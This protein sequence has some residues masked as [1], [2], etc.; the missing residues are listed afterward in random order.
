M[1]V[2]GKWRM[3]L[4]GARDALAS[5]LLDAMAPAA[6][7]MAKTAAVGAL[8]Q[9][10]LARPGVIPIISPIFIVLLSAGVS[11]SDLED[12]ERMARNPRS[13]FPNVVL[14]V[15]DDQ[16]AQMSA[17]GTK[18]VST[19]FMDQLAREGTLFTN[20]FS[21]S[22]SCSPSRASILTGMYP[23]AH[24][25]WRNVYSPSLEDDDIQ[26]TRSATPVDHVG[27]HEYLSTLP[28][29]LRANGYFTAI[30]QKLGAGPPW[31][32]PYDARRHTWR[33]PRLFKESIGQFIEEAGGRP[34]FIQANISPP[35]R[36]FDYFRFHEKMSPQFLPHPGRIEV[37]GYLAD[38]PVMREDLREY[39][40]SI[41]VADAAVGAVLEALKGKDVY[42]DALIIFTSDNGEP[43]H[44]AKASPYYAGLHVPFIAKGPG[45]P[46]N[47]TSDA[48][49]SHID[50]MPTILDYLGIGIPES[51][52]GT[53]LNFSPSGSGRKAAVVHSRKY[54]FGEH[55]SHGPNRNQ[56]YPSRA[57]FDGRFY[58]IE[59]LLPDRSY[60]LPAD[61]REEEVWGNRSY[62]ATLQARE[63]HPVQYRL[64]KQLESGRSREELYDMQN[65]PW[66]LS[67]LAGSDQHEAK[68]VELRS[69]LAQWRI[70]TGD[71]ANDP[72]AIK[73]R[74]PMAIEEIGA[75]IEA[76]RPIVRGDFDVYLG[77]DKLALVY[78]RERCRREDF[79]IPFFLHVVPVD[80]DVLSDGH[81][82]HGFDNIGIAARGHEIEGTCIAIGHLP[83]YPIAA[84][85]TGQYMREGRVR[86]GSFLPRGHR[87]WEGEMRLDI[88]AQWISGVIEHMQ[89]VIRSDFDVYHAGNLL[90]YT[91]ERCSDEDVAPLFFVHV[92]PADEDDLPVP[93]R[94]H[95][96]DFLDFRFKAR[97]LPLDFHFDN[98]PLP[99]HVGCAAVI[100]L[101]DYDVALVRTGQYVPD[102]TRLWHGELEIGKGMR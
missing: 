63:T 66:Q 23:H 35:H 28:E 86:G 84:I 20:A 76:S 44:R 49:I 19:P 3:F 11:A 53:S 101:P 99:S 93:Y 5:L 87:P 85:R 37:P 55:H 60:E 34:F 8:V 59:N 68:L 31:K 33:T 45:I 77:V 15:T 47:L 73:T 1:T 29:I 62:R 52:Q 71:E 26:F 39:Y 95:G 32:F 94:Q 24:G 14:I 89:P 91:G 42:D 78:A 30:T 7:A 54:V 64:L 100:D 79:A 96:V 97:Q 75:W 69:V 80:P 38:T 81:R 67:N 9:H 22:P 25:L 72:E 43:Y 48:L 65:D 57:V 36:N 83:A 74:L 58:Y 27:I 4:C 92:V 56:H 2:T 41:Q 82:Q 17:L 51:V 90:L 21:V 12:P 13:P 70:R 61:L 10:F 102:G 40:G 46:A 98:L 50:I 16:G 18:G 88:D 6:S